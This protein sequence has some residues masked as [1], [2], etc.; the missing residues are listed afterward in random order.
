MRDFMS[1]EG[2]IKIG[3]Q[4]FCQANTNEPDLD[5]A[6]DVYQH[7]AFYFLDIVLATSGKD[8]MP[9]QNKGDNHTNNI[10]QYNCYPVAGELI[11]Q[12]TAKEISAR[13]NTTHDQELDKLD[14]RFFLSFSL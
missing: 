5:N 10:S 12:D 6:K 7:E 8:I 1:I 2:E 14:M 13:G 3:K 11:Y 4:V 9:E